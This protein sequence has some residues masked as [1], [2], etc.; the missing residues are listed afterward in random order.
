VKAG[1]QLVHAHLAEFGAH[2]VQGAAGLFDVWGQ[3]A[4]PGA[5]GRLDLA[6]LALHQLAEL[7]GGGLG[8][9]GVDL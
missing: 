4:G 5:G 8:L 1:S 7:S 6:Q 9:A 2:L 3:G